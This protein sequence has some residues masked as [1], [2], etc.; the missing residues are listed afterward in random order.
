MKFQ[1]QIHYVNTALQAD[2]AK[3][4]DDKKDADAPSGGPPDSGTGGAAGGA[5]ASGSSANTP[6]PQVK[7]QVVF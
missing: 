1:A 6:A 4:S 5:G 3:A 2:G 7:L